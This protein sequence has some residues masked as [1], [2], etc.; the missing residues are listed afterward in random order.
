[1]RNK[2]SNC[3]DMPLKWLAKV[4]MGSAYSFL[5]AVLCVACSRENEVYQD[6]CADPNVRVGQHETEQI[7]PADK[8]EGRFSVHKYEF[9]GKGPAHK[10]ADVKKYELDHMGSR[11][12]DVS[13][14]V[15]IEWP[16]SQ[17]GLSK[18]ALAK[19]RKT[20]LWMAFAHTPEVK[21]YSVPESLGETEESLRKHDRSESMTRSCGRRT[22][23]IERLMM[24]L[25]FSPP[26]GPSW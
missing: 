7:E 10:M 3:G 1:M 22:V 9:S 19:V 21:P 18:D 15:H 20:I 13:V 24:S 11:G 6:P 4:T 26:I 12:S 16:E 23:T 14:K 2:G 25:A 17:S 5:I 8:H